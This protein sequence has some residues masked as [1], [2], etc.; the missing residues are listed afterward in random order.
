MAPKGSR[1]V[2]THMFV[3]LNER[4]RRLDHANYS[5]CINNE[6]KMNN[7][8]CVPLMKKSCL[9]SRFKVLKTLRLRMWQTE[10]LM[11]RN[12]GLKIIHLVRDPRGGL[13]SRERAREMQGPLGMEANA[14]CLEMQK[15]YYTRLKLEEM[16]PESYMQIKYE[17]FAEYPERNAKLI[18]NFLGFQYPKNVDLWLF[19]NTKIGKKNDGTFGTSR[20]NSNATAHAWI[21]KIPYHFA[22]EID[23]VCSDVYPV[24]GY[25]KFDEIDPGRKPGDI[26]D[27]NFSTKAPYGIKW[28]EVKNKNI[29]RMSIEEQILMRK[30]EEA[31]RD[32]L[33]RIGAIKPNTEVLQ[34]ITG[35]VRFKK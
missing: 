23:S 24:F 33:R 18:Y 34:R 22:T 6:Q 29:R 2:E 16:F 14:R 3:S 19:A 32:V 26:K 35:R 17:D 7:T 21:K 30:R 9:T 1:F 20:S 10:E 12:P 28:L 11:V 5:S 8:K 25:R 31:K 27:Y 13:W 15:D 4:H